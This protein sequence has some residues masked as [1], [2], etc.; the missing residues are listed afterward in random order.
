LLKN[1]NILRLV[2]GGLVG[3][4]DVGS[5]LHF[6]QRNPEGTASQASGT[7]M[8]LSIPWIFRCDGGRAIDAWRYFVSDGVVTG[9]DLCVVAVRTRFPQ[10]TITLN[11]YKS[12]VLMSTPPCRRR[13]EIGSGKCYE[14]DKYYGIDAFHLENSETNIQREIMKNGPVTAS[15][16]VYEDFNYYFVGIYKVRCLAAHSCDSHW[17]RSHHPD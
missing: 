14:N 2:L 7:V 1:D 10:K 11:S 5:P 17:R 9:G 16:Q 12:P 6:Y 3:C 4:H 13:C 8:R 15:F